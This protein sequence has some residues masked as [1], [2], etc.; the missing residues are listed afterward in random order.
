VC[1]CALHTHL[2]SSHGGGAV[3]GNQTGRSGPS[4]SHTVD[5]LL[6]V[7]PARWPLPRRTGAHAV[8]TA[9]GFG[10]CDCKAGILA[11]PEQTDDSAKFLVPKDQAFW[12]QINGSVG[13]YL[14]WRLHAANEPVGTG[15][16]MEGEGARERKLQGTGARVICLEFRIGRE[17]ARR[18]WMASQ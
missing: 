17:R 8:A 13:D 14:G 7:A 6:F 12:M 4:G 11:R 18:L 15:V 9:F 5:R 2:P 10:A 16:A 3:P 1:Y